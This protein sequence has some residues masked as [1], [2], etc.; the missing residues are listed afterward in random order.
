[1]LSYIPCRFCS[2]IQEEGHQSRDHGFFKVHA[3]YLIEERFR[4]NLTEFNGEADHVHILFELPPSAA[5]SMVICSLKTQLSKEA[6]KRY[7]EQIRGKLWKD[8]FWSDSYFP[9]TTG[10]ADIE[11]L[12]K[13]IQTQGT[14]KPRSLKSDHRK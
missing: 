11:T 6:R 10:G 8:S 14:K 5:P 13:Y 4:G 12:E 7:P 3:K 2:Q 1:M 9:A